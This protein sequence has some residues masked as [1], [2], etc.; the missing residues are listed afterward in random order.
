MNTA[1]VKNALTTV[2]SNPRYRILNGIRWSSFQ[3]L[4]KT[5]KKKIFSPVRI[6]DSGFASNRVFKPS[7]GY[8]EHQNRIP[9]IPPHRIRSPI[10]S[11]PSRRFETLMRNKSEKQKR[12]FH[13]YVVAE[14]P[15]ERCSR[16]HFQLSRSPNS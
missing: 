2:G 10:V 5:N 9:T 12:F 16:L 3:A 6:D 7:K 13:C 4:K 15:R 1:F 8:I 11:F 14:L